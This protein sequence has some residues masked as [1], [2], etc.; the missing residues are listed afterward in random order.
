M[1]VDRHGSRTVSVKLDWEGVGNG[2]YGQLQKVALTATLKTP[3]LLRLDDYADSVIVV[4]GE[5]AA[6]IVEVV[7][8]VSR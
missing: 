3:T 1:M 6:T 8:L 7:K 4:S 5:E 2:V